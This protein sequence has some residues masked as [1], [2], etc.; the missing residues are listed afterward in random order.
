M[1]H[2]CLGRTARVVVLVGL[3]FGCGGHDSSGPGRAPQISDLRLTQ[4]V[5]SNGGTIRWNVT[6]FD[7]QADLFQG[8]CV[9]RST[10][11]DISG[12]INTLGPGGDPNATTG[13]I[14]CIANYQGRGLTV[15]GELFVIDRGGHE[16]NHL[17]F[18]FVTESPANGGSASSTLSFDRAGL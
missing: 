6:Y 10:I 12:P 1:A 11:G 16:S 18:T 3:L 4:T 14:F 17:T 5:R 8:Q 7:A 2:I 13:T 15:N 9:V